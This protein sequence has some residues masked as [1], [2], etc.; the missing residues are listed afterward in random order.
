MPNALDASVN[1]D[2]NSLCKF[3]CDN[4][5]ALSYPI[6]FFFFLLSRLR[7]RR[8]LTVDGKTVFVC[9]CY[10]CNA[11]SYTMKVMFSEGQ[12]TVCQT[13]LSSAVVHPLGRSRGEWGHVVLWW[14]GPC[15]TYQGGVDYKKAYHTCGSWDLSPFVWCIKFYYCYFI[16]IF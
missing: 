14:W 1:K 12:L 8:M 9:Q 13:I 5:A 6:V 15:C 4:S 10:S 7:C 11:V 16:N 3:F 2:V